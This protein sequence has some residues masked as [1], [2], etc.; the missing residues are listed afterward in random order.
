MRKPET[1]PNSRLP[2]AIIILSLLAML[3]AMLEGFLR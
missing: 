2:V 3:A 1:P